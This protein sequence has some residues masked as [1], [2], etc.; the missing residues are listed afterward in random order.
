MNSYAPPGHCGVAAF[1]PGAGHALGAQEVRA[2]IR[3]TA[4]PAVTSNSTLRWV[5]YVCVCVVFF[6]SGGVEMII[7]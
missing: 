2:A 3:G 5:M 1:Y 6:F 7:T 4:A